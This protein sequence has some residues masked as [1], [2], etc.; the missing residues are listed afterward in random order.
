M[1]NWIQRDQLDEEKY[2]HCISNSSESLVYAYSWY[3]DI[4]CDNWGV[5]V[6]DDYKAVMPVPFRKKY[7][8]KYAHPP[9]WVLQLGIFS[10]E[11]EMSTEVFIKA[12]KK[13]FRFIELR[14]NH[15]NEF[16]ESNTEERHFQELMLDKSME[17]IRKLYQS[18]RRKDLKKADK[19]GL[20]KK[21]NDDS[22][23]LIQLFQDN[24]G[25]RTPEIKPKDYSNLK[26]LIQKCIGKDQGEILS[27]Y[28]KDQ[29]VASAFFLKHQ[30]TATILCSSTDF[31]NRNNGA[32]TFLIDTAIQKYQA[33]FE[34][35]NFGGSSMSSIAK[36]FF[37]FGAKDI[38]YPFLKQKPI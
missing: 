16:S 12:I 4:V 27:I 15:Q 28:E 6:L 8:I 7:L 26:K 33:D 25:K 13:K 32:N 24:V 23:H 17:D 19:F 36:Y 10:S 38:R 30:K 31:N 21:W 14:L 35:F 1:I 2:N 37:S 9:L 29:L 18:D 22:Q 20:I 3:L 5:F 11:K 34:V